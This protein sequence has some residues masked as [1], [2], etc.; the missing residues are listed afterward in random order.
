MKKLAD[1][2]H[3]VNLWRIECSCT[4]K[5]WSQ[6]GKKSCGALF[7]HKVGTIPSVLAEW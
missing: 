3:N 6:K 7:E 2:D 5:D 4:G 1:K